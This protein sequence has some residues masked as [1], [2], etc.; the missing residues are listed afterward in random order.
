MLGRIPKNGSPA[1]E[2]SKQESLAR[3]YASI[4]P[5]SSCRNENHE[6]TVISNS[7]YP[8]AFKTSL[9]SL[10]LIQI[11]SAASSSNIKASAVVKA[12]TT[13]RAFGLVKT[14]RIYIRHYSQDSCS[15]Q[16]L[17]IQ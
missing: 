8:F 12:T 1:R 7:P 10:S 13:F 6:K 17:S 5:F 9:S 14:L 4:P 15:S 3:R 16:H 2:F 11:L